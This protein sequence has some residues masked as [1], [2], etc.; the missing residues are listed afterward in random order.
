LGGSGGGTG[1][2]FYVLLF[3]KTFWRYMQY[4]VNSLINNFGSAIFGFLYI[5]IW[6]G[7]LGPGQEVVGFGRQETRAQGARKVYDG[8]LEE[9]REKYPMPSVLEV[10]FHGLVDTAGLPE[11][12]RY[13]A[14]TGKATLAF[15]K[16]E[17]RPMPL[18]E[19]FG[20]CGEVRDIQIQA[21][22]IEEM[23][24]TIYETE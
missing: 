15:D 20:A 11:G 7:T 1:V 5:A 22:K 8:T 23:I 3:R 13:D 12:A 2:S 9:L 14:A 6:Q 16:R 4:R 10:E 18:I 17:T 24:Q 19:Q 21:P